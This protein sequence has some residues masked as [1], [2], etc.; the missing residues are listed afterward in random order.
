[1]I[2]VL[3]LKKIF[4]TEAGEIPV[5]R[6]LDFGVPRGGMFAVMGASGVGKS[7][8]LHILG[9]ID[10]PT[11]GSVVL[12]DADVFKMPDSALPGFRNR[13]IGFVFQFHHLLPEFTAL[14]NVM[15]PGLIEGRRPRA[16]IA[17]DALS[18]MEELGIGHRVSHRPGEM[19]GG[20]QQRTAVARALIMSPK[21]V[22]AD[23]PTGNLD[24]ST[25]EELFD[26][27]IRLNRERGI[28]F[29]IATHNE[30]LASKCHKILR[31]R[32][33]LMEG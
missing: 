24:T 19:S 23:E 21:V 22:L 26:V 20:E 3:G 2:K 5:L 27:L 15:M 1:M 8:L 13:T 7:T 10:R 16:E 17:S 30:A 33:G 14:E 32:D 25:G 4:R 9:A 31:M 18:L 29:L 28:T 11:G 6:G 12:D